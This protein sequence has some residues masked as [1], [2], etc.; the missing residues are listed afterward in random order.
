MGSVASAYDNFEY[1]CKV[2]KDAA[3]AM[4]VKES[5]MCERAIEQHQ[6]CDPLLDPVFDPVFDPVL[7]LVVFVVAFGALLFFR[8]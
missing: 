2:K 1:M 7:M 5:K 8:S 6:H 3:I 4:T